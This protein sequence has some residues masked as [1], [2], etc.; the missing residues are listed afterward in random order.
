MTTYVEAN[1]DLFFHRFNR[2]LIMSNSYVTKRQSTKLLGEILLDRAYYRV[3]IRYVARWDNLKLCMNLL[4][5]DQK[6]IQYEGFH[7]F[8]VRSPV[9]FFSD[10]PDNCLGFRCKPEQVCGGTAPSHKQPRTS[11]AI[12]PSIPRRPHG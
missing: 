12:P 5:D 8:K 11:V 4:K 2:S 1:F 10:Q 9:P 7:V 3:M 6:M